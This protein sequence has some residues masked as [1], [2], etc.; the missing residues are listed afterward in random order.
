M[1]LPAMPDAPDALTVA[2]TARR[3]SVSPRQV[4]RL[5]HDGEVETVRI[6]TRGVRVLTRSLLDY[7]ERQAERE[8]DAR[9]G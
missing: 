1:V 5:I 7:L 2:E 8:R 6:G 9:E 3:L 4:W